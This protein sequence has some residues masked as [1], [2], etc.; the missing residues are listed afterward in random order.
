MRKSLVATVVMAAVAGGCFTV[1][2]A[3]PSSGLQR[4]QLSRASVTGEAPTVQ[5][6]TGT[7]TE[8]LKL[9]LQPGGTTGWHRHKVQGI[10]LV[11]KGTFT[12]YGLD[13]PPCDP[14][15]IAPGKALFFGPHAHHAHLVQNRGSEPLEITVLN[16]NLAPEQRGLV[17]AD[18]P[19]ECPAD[20]Y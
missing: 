18:R 5:F 13:G 16:F 20:L 19:K 3:T 11:D 7:E 2:K 15:E 14:V 6:Q 17:D 12:S 8:V 9:V 4:S 10:F 1:A